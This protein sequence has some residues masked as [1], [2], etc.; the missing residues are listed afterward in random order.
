M[1]RVYVPKPVLKSL[2]RFP[3]R[4]A[5]RIWA[6]LD[7][8]KRAPFGG[9]IRDLGD[10]TYRRRVGAYRIRFDVAW[11]TRTVSVLWVRRRTSIT[12]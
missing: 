5:D 12:Y 3:A 1:W 9:D 10:G 6:A 4:D 7:A 11:N 8:M 2:G